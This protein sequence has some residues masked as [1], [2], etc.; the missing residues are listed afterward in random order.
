MELKFFD[1]ETL[2]ECKGNVSARIVYDDGR[3]IPI[4]LKE[5][6]LISIGRNIDTNNNIYEIAAIATTNTEEGEESVNKDGIEATITLKMIWVDNYGPRNELTSVEGELSES[7]AEVSGSLYKYGVKYNIGQQKMSSGTS[8]YHNTDFK[9]LKL[10]VYYYIRFVDVS[11]K[12]E[13][14]ITN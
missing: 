10:F 14:E 8:F 13:L 5:T 2:Q 6:K 12:L 4:E 9:G 1:Q 3:I 11:W 7:N